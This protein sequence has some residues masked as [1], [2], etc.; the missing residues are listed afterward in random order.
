L[1]A[2][3]NGIVAAPTDSIMAERLKAAFRSEI[4]FLNSRMSTAPSPA[5]AIATPGCE[6]KTIA[7]PR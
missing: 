3:Q 4:C 7:I 1:L 6:R 5:I 2:I